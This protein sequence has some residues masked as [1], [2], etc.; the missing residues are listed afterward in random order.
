MILVIDQ[1]YLALCSADEADSGPHPDSL[2]CGLL[3]GHL[4]GLGWDTWRRAEA[5]DLTRIVHEYNRNIANDS[6]I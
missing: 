1:C 3:H 6:V 4:D 2:G 5:T